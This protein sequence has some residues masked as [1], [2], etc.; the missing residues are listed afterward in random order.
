MTHRFAPLAVVFASFAFAA[1]TIEKA[2]A[3]PPPAAPT[4]APAPA[5]APVATLD[6]VCKPIG[7]WRV[8]GPTGAQEIKIDGSP[9]KPGQYDVS[10]K[11][12]TVGQGTGTAEGQSFKVDL[13]QATGGMYNCTLTPGCKSMSCGFTGQQ[14]QVFQKAD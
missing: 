2:P 7:L 1:C 8:A 14:P 3:S 13:G 10:Y 5:P 4:A 11:G 9:S 6:E 12:A